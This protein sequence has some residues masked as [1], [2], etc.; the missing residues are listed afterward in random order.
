[1]SDRVW[2]RTESGL[3]LELLA[4]ALGWLD[5]TG[6]EWMPAGVE[7]RSWR[8]ACGCSSERAVTTGGP[9]GPERAK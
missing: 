5:S 4:T 1:V 3:T 6:R 8:A 9:G 7:G 2:V